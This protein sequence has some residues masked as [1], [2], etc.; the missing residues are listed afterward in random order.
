MRV[1]RGTDGAGRLWD[2]KHDVAAHFR[3]REPHRE[4]CDEDDRIVV[5]T[6]GRRRPFETAGSAEGGMPSATPGSRPSIHGRPDCDEDRSRHGTS[7]NGRHRHVQEISCRRRGRYD[8][9]RR[10]SVSA[11]VPSY[12]TYASTTFATPSAPGPHV[13]GEYQPLIGRNAGHPPAG[14]TEHCALCA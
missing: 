3:A 2:G 13:F 1:L 11:P 14:Q 6:R 10:G 4:D 7:S 5:T 9:P 8:Q 12:T